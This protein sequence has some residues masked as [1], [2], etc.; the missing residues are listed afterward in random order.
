VGNRRLALHLSDR[1]RKHP[2][3]LRPQAPPRRAQR[4]VHLGPPLQR[5]DRLLARLSLALPGN[6]P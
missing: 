1:L 5:P 3:G 2:S 6:R 4:P